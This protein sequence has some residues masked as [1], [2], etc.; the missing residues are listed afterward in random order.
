ME[1]KIREKIDS[2]VTRNFWIT[3][4]PEHIFEE[5]ASFCEVE[6]S[7]NYSMGLKLLLDFK[8]ENVKEIFLFQKILELESKINQL[9][10]EV[11]IDD[12]KDKKKTFGSTNKV[13]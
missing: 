5:F 7:N 3:K 4:C 12:K 6:T 13:F 2:M 1:E 11:L 8:K 10:P 9:E